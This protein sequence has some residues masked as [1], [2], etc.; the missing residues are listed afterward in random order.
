MHLTQGSDHNDISRQEA[1]LITTNSWQELNVHNG[2]NKRE[3]LQKKVTNNKERSRKILC[4][5]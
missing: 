4:T 2:K 3:A 5:L 1:G